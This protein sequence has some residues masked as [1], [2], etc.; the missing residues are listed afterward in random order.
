MLEVTQPGVHPYQ[1]EVSAGGKPLASLAGTL[2]TA[3]WQVTFFRWPANVDPRKDLAAY[4]Q[5][6]SGPTAVS[7]ALDQLS[8]KYGMRGPS[9]LGISPRITAARLGRDHFGMVA[10]TRLPLAAGRWELMTESDDGVRVIVDGKTLIENWT[11]HGPTRDKG[12]LE[13]A[14]ARVVDITVEHFQI[15]GYAVLDFSLAQAAN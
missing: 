2:L 12:I 4:R 14:A 7:D 6:A 15:D 5:L 8:F 9:E 13:L 11:W 10:H 3:P 1:L